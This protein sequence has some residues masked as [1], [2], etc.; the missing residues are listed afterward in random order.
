M[1]SRALSVTQIRRLTSCDRAA[2]ITCGN[3][4]G[5]PLAL[6][7]GDEAYTEMM[8]HLWAAP[9]R[10]TPPQNGLRRKEIVEVFASM[11]H[12]LRNT[13]EGRLNHSI[14]SAVLTVPFLNGIGQDVGESVIKSAFRQIGMKY[15][16]V[17][18]YRYIGDPLTYIEDS[19]LAAHRLGL[20]QPYTVP[21]EHCPELQRDSYMFV[22]YYP[23]GLEILTTTD[24]AIAY[25][26]TS[27]LYSDYSLGSK[28][29]HENP[30]GAYYWEQVRDL[31]TLALANAPWRNPRN[32]KLIFYGSCSGDQKMRAIVDDTLRRFL[33]ND[34]M[35]NIVNDGVDSIY[36]GALG[37]AEFAKRAPYCRECLVLKSRSGL[38]TQSVKDQ[39]HYML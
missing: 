7:P 21:Y 2:A 26:P 33:A 29:Q 36:A 23:D 31:I 6:V 27:Y 12:S 13:A 34:E 5:T 10:S 16:P 14:Q 11:L 17:H 9:Y 37:A 28:M 24:G 25:H 32:G 15:I 35:P 8:F 38:R 39:W 22:G 18:V 3:D 30:D 19:I 20:C 1:G 4:T